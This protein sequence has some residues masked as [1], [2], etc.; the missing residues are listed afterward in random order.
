MRGRSFLINTAWCSRKQE[1]QGELLFP[2]HLWQSDPDLLNTADLVISVLHH[3]YNWLASDNSRELK[4]RMDALSDV[5]LTGHEHDAVGYTKVTASGEQIE[6]LEGGV[7][8]DSNNAENSTFTAVVLD[9]DR[10]E[11]SHYFFRWAGTHY[12]PGDATAIRPFL[13][14][15]KRLA[16][17]LPYTEQFQRFL[18]DPGATFAHPRKQS[19]ILS[20][21]FISP[22]LKEIA[23]DEA[24]NSA[25]IRGDDVASQLV[26]F[27]RVLIIG[28]DTSGKTSLAKTLT[29]S[30]RGHG[31]VPL[32]VDG[33]HLRINDPNYTGKARLLLLSIGSTAQLNESYM[34]S[35]RKIGEPSL[36]TITIF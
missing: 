26:R 27:E 32:F 14:N 9:I 19:L 1:I 34:S 4:A 13:R 6:Y 20:D 16:S 28:S 12:Q 3:P 18:D 7:L 17:E 10:K 15:Q 36:S 25:F 29:D 8:Q 2:V 21:F 23:S 24:E 35:F 31:F 5:V 33:G 22:D 11:Q 30:L